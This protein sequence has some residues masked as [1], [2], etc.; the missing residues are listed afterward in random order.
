M[1]RKKPNAFQKLVRGTLRGIILQ[2]NSQK[3][4]PKTKNKTST[5][6]SN[7]Q[8]AKSTTPKE[9]HWSIKEC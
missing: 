2:T 4:S 5:T 3:Q 8:K 1:A 6:I 9:W 7:R